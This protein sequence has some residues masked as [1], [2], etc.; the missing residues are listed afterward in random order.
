M[1]NHSPASTSHG[2]T[3]IHSA[4]SFAET[5]A[6]LRSALQTHRIKIF[7]TI[8]QQAEA[9]AVGV[10]MPPAVLIIFGNPQAGTP[11]IVARPLSAIDLPLKV[12]I[13]EPSPGEVLVTF[14]TAQYLADRHG[15][16]HDL[17]TKVAPAERLIADALGE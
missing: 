8:D 14:N 5:V 7:T 10:T 17:V 1:T 2:L 11:L 4:H 6:R 12:L 9:A 3:T 13:S 16:P 15:V